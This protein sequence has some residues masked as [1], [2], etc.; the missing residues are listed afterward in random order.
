[1]YKPN[2][3]MESLRQQVVRVFDENIY[4]HIIGD[5][6]LLDNIQPETHGNGCAVPT[7]MLILSSLDFIGFMLK[8]N[9]NPDETEV[10]IKT[11]L[12]HNSYFNPAIYTE[13]TIRELIIF[14]RHGVMHTFYPRQTS[15]KIYGLHKS[16]SASLIEQ[17]E[18]EGY[19][20]TSLNVNT[21]SNDF[22]VFIDRLYQEVKN[23]SDEK[24]LTRINKGYKVTYPVELTQ[25]S[26]T[27]TQTT[28]PYGVNYNK[29]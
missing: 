8:E 13:E 3:N 2:M 5:L 9:G 16:P 27:T 19:T 24:L 4:S 20:I 10:N 6:R 12:V 21:F 1:M 25:S 17:V 29:R 18:S 7:I 22:K 28:I 11:A 26:T 23:T 14:Y 15:N